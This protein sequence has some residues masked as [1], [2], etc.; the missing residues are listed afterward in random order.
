[1]ITTYL[2]DHLERIARL[3]EALSH[4][5]RTPLSVITNTLS[6]AEASTDKEDLERALQRGHGIAKILK[7]GELPSTLTI[8]K[9]NV[10]KLLDEALW[11]FEV[12]WEKRA[13]ELIVDS[14]R[15]WLWLLITDIAQALSNNKAEGKPLKATFIGEP[16]EELTL[17]AELKAASAVLTDPLNSFLDLRAQGFDLSAVQAARLDLLT[18]IS[19]TSINLSSDSLTVKI[20]FHSI[21]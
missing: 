10:Q 5:I 2:R 8:S 21:E 16:I 1:M 4:E 3:I 11:S 17:R 6:Y 12:M 18:L 19:T 14:S 7:S 9:V 13:G 15:P 20:K